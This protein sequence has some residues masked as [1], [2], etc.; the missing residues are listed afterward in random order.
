[1]IYD[2]QIPIADYT[3]LAYSGLLSLQT[4]EVGLPMGGTRKFPGVKGRLTY[5]KQSVQD[6]HKYIH[7]HICIYEY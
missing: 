5:L 4:P 7:T 6:M 3:S 1:M 2:K